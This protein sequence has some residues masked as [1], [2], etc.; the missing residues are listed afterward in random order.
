[1]RVDVIPP[2]SIAVHVKRISTVNDEGKMHCAAVRTR[3]NVINR[4]RTP[5][6]QCCREGFRKKCSNCAV[7]IMSCMFPRVDAQQARGT[8][9][10]A[11]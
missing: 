10:A 4:Q 8:T 11:T 5:S 1:M 3:F 9:V 6:Q 7:R 2:N